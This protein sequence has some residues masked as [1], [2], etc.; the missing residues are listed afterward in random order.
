MKRYCIF[1][2]LGATFLF[3]GCASDLEKLDLVSTK[4]VSIQKRQEDA[5][6]NQAA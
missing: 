2:L 6:L 3:V 5:R 1:L 4:D